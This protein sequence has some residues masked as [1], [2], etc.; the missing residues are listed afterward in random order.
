MGLSFSDDASFGAYLYVNSENLPEGINRIDPVTRVRTSHISFDEGWG[1]TRS[2]GGAFGNFLY[3]DGG[4]G[5][6]AVMRIDSSM[7]ASVFTHLGTDGRA[8]DL[9]FGGGSFGDLL[10]MVERNPTGVDLLTIDSS[11]TA[12]TFVDDVIAG[13]GWMAFS[14]GGVWGDFLYLSDSLGGNIWRIDPTGAQTLFA[15]GLTV[16]SGIAFAPDGSSLYVAQSNSTDVV[17]KISPT[18]VIPEPTSLI[19]FGIGGIGLLGYG[20]RRK[21]KD[22]SELKKGNEANNAK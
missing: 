3:A 2:T 22:K 20:W 16:T 4:A 1:L 15:S 7:T 11:G 8:F 19:L 10:Y 21:R 18:G 9:K 13:S 12:T 5:E 17:L 14:P 6:N